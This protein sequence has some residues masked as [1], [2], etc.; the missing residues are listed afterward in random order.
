MVKRNSLTVYSCSPYR[1]AFIELNILTCMFMIHTHTYTHACIHIASY[2]YN[3]S[4]IENNSEIITWYSINLLSLSR[5][6]FLSFLPN[7]SSPSCS[8][9]LSFFFLFF[10]LLYLLLFEGERIKPCIKL[11]RRKPYN[12]AIFTRFP[13]IILAQCSIWQEWNEEYE[14]SRHSTCINFIVMEHDGRTFA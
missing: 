6:F 9:S 7:A 8:Q 2:P 13:N 1:I 10:F 5:L 11:W 12:S 4:T 3:F 14:C